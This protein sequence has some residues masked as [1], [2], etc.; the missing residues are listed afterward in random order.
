MLQ[1]YL[2]Y[3]N[4]KTADLKNN[5]SRYLARVRETGETIVVC[6]R[7]TPVAILSPIV[8]NEDAEW[9]RYRTEA[10]ARA[11]K[12]GLNLQIP[13]QRPRKTPLPEVRPTVAPDG[14][15]DLATIALARKGKDY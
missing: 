3:M 14:R 2:G 4:V 12:I 8:R 10:L 11:R 1:G 5:L 6:D 15:T 7:E 13:L 9:N